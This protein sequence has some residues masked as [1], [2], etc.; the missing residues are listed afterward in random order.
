VVR[1]KLGVIPKA[2]WRYDKQ[3]AVAIRQQTVMQGSSIGKPTE[4]AIGSTSLTV[5]DGVACDG[6]VKADPIPRERF[7]FPFK[8][9]GRWYGIANE[10]H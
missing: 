9:S 5:V 3:Q 7:R 6:L 1:S 10:L 8:Y 2:T 4:T